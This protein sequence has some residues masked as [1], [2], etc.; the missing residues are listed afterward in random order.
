MNGFLK[1]AACLRSLLHSLRSQ[2]ENTKSL[3]RINQKTSSTRNVDL[4][5]KR[6]D[7]CEV[8]KSLVQPVTQTQVAQPPL[9]AIEADSETEHG[10]SPLQKR[11][12]YVDTPVDDPC[13]IYTGESLK[14]LVKYFTSNPQCEF[15]G[16]D[17]NFSG[18]SFKNQGHVCR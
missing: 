12:I 3:L 2:W 16:G 7:Y 8:Q 17:I 9:S 5:E 6:L 11:Q 1:M 14:S 4:L 15:C 13:F 10:R 18:M